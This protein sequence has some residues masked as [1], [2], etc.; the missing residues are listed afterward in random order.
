MFFKKQTGF[1]TVNSNE[2]AQA[3]KGDYFL[4]DV[5][6]K[7]EFSQGH[8]KGATLIP[9]SEL[10]GRIGEIEQHKEKPVLVYCLS[11][12]RSRSAG[13]FLASSGFKNVLDL[14]GGMMAWGSRR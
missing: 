1:S 7:S 12:A 4:L 5:R 3:M 2:F 11:G 6:T 10:Q 9:V 8:I 14:R 13:R